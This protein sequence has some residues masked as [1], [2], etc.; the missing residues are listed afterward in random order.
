LAHKHTTNPPRPSQSRRLELATFE[1]LLSTHLPDLHAHLQGAGLQPVLYAAQMLMTWFASPFP[2]QFGGRVLDLLLQSGGHGCNLLLRVA[3]SLLEALQTELL[4]LDDFESLI[5]TIKV[6]TVAALWFGLLLSYRLAQVCPLELLNPQPPPP[7]PSLQV[8]PLKW[9]HHTYRRV[10]DKALSPAWISEE[11]INTARSTAA[12]QI[13]AAAQAGRPVS[14]SANPRL[15]PSLNN[16]TG[17]AAAAV[18]EGGSEHPVVD[19][20]GSGASDS[21]LSSGHVVVDGCGGGYLASGTFPRGGA[22]L[23]GELEALMSDLHLIIPGSTGSS[24]DG[25]EAAGCSSN[26]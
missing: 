7:L 11:E 25:S 8:T 9:S 22:Q 26:T 3:L 5:T 17:D 4:S 6:R 13:A 20:N 23:G 14:F 10:L 19:G 21:T 1:R 2:F 16:S 18:D 24:D 12:A 15:V